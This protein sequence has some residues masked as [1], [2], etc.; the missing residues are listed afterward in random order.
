MNTI[1]RK[2]VG[3]M[4]YV[5]RGPSQ[6]KVLLYAEHLAEA[7]QRAIE[8]FRPKKKERGLIW[9]QLAESPIATESL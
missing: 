8:H 3:D 2:R 6:A 5:A 9:V 4:L 1:N 7:Q